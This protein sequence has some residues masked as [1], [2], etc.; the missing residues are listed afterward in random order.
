MIWGKYLNRIWLIKQMG[1]C[2]HKIVS[3]FY[4]II[5]TKS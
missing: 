2:T 4:L 1:L 5:K 3:L